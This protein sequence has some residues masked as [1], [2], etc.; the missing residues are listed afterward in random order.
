MAVNE[1]DSSVNFSIT[2][3]TKK[4]K[5]L[6]HCC[7]DISSW[8]SNCAPHQR[9]SIVSRFWN[10]QQNSCFG[11]APAL[12]SAYG[13]RRENRSQIS[14]CTPQC[15]IFSLYTYI[16]LHSQSMATN[17]PRSCQSGCFRRHFEGVPILL[18]FAAQYCDIMIRKGS[19]LRP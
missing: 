10:T 14:P 2:I 1:A 8:R 4:G 3:S 18:Y 11:G 7:R 13:Q 19:D 9:S 6:S 15:T 16:Q 17:A 12:A 5:Q